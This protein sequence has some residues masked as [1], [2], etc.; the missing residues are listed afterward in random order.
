[1]SKSLF[2]VV[3][4]DEQEKGAARIAEAFE[5]SDVYHVD[6]NTFVVAYKGLSID[7]AIASGIFNDKDRTPGDTAGVVFKLNGSYTGYSRQ[8]LWEWLEEMERGS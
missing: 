3:L 6:S 8:S 7:V 1:M 2:A 5:S 4:T